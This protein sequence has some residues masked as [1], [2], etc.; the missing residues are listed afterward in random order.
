MRDTLEEIGAILLV[1]LVIVAIALSL[2][3]PLTYISWRNF[4]KITNTHYTYW[5]YFWNADALKL[6]AKNIKK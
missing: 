5:D 1:I 3:L 4:S 2:T 6:Q